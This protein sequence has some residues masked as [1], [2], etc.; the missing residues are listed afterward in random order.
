MLADHMLC[1]IDGARATELAH[2]GSDISRAYGNGALCEDDYRRL[3]EAIEAR[4]QETRAARQ[5]AP[6]SAPKAVLRPRRVIPRSPD[7]AASRQRR[8]DIGQERWLPPSIASKLT[9]AEIAVLSVEVREIVKHGVCSL[10]IDAI[11]GMAGVCATMVKNTRRLATLLGFIRVI[12]RPRR[13]QKSKTNLVYALS[14]ELRAWIATRRRMIGAIGG[15]LVPST[16]ANVERKKP[17]GIGLHHRNH[18]HSACGP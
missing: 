11:A 6:L 8:R 18:Q 15:K 7:R 17:S 16:Q 3:W 10:P 9:Q 4:R 14:P 13:G 5:P 12:H 1:V 2:V